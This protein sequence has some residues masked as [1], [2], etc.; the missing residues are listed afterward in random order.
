M[1]RGLCGSTATWWLSLRS[2]GCWSLQGQ[3]TAI[4]EGRPQHLFFPQAK[5]TE[6]VYSVHMVLCLVKFAKIFL[7]SF[8]F[9]K[10]VTKII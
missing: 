1:L 2:G 4:P 8:F 3:T 10:R 7:Y 9:L 6:D 5:Q